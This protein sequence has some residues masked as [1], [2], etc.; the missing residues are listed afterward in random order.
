M[1]HEFLSYSN[2][3]LKINGGLKRPPQVP[4]EWRTDGTKRRDALRRDGIDQILIKMFCANRSTF[5][6]FQFHGV[7][8]RLIT[9]TSFSSEGRS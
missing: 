2:G 7:A 5:K 8:V 3:C 4:D 1:R 9:T 6:R